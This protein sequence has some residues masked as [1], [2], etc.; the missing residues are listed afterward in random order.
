MASLRSFA[1]ELDPAA[2][3][4]ALGGHRTGSGWL[5]HCPAHDDQ[6]PSLSITGNGDGKLLVHCHAG[7]SQDEVITALRKLGLWPEQKAKPQIVAV[8]PYHDE[9]GELLYQVIRLEPKSFR[10]RQP[11]GKGG[12][13]WN[14]NGTRLVPYRLP[15][16][17]G[18]Q[19][20]FIVEGEKDADTIR[21]WGL[22]GSTNP[23][24]AL[25]WQP[26]FNQYFRDKLVAILP[27]KDNAGHKHALQ[28]ARS[29]LG[30]AR[31]VRI[32]ELPKAKDVSDWAEAGGT[33]EQLQK[34]V[35]QAP[36]LTPESLA[37]LEQRWGV[38]QPASQPVAQV[39]ATTES[40][41]AIQVNDRPLRDVTCDALKA[42]QG[43]NNPPVLFVRAGQL[44]VVQTDEHGR[45]SILPVTEAHLRGR[46]DR[47]ADFHRVLASGESKPVAPPLDVVRDLLALGPEQW[48]FPPLTGVSS[49]PLVRPDGTI[50]TTEGYDAK[51]QVYY[52]DQG[53]QLPPIP[54]RPT[55]QDVGKALDWIDHALGDFPFRGEADRANA[56][57]M[58]LTPLI[59]YALPR[60]ACLP[61]FLVD[62]PQS[63]TGKTL[64]A[65]VLA[66]LATGDTAALRAAPRDEDEWRKCLLSVLRAGT[67]LVVFDD[68]ATTLSA[69][70]LAGVITAHRWSDR[71][72]GQTAELALP[73]NTL[74]VATGNNL[75]VGGDLPRRSVWVRLDA[76][77]PRPWQGRDFRHPLLERWV[78]RHRGELLS[79]LLTLVRAWF[80]AGRPKG[81]A[82]S[83]LSF[84]PWCQMT[85]GI[86]THA[87]IA[88]FLGNAE[89]L[90]QDPET[91]GWAAFL[92]ALW[93]RFGRQPFT[94]A[95]L[96]DRV[97]FDADLRGTLP[98]E[99]AGQR[100]QRRWGRALSSQCERRFILGGVIYWLKPVG[101]M[102]GRQRWRVHAV[103]ERSNA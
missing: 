13:L 63:G 25:K 40:L 75:A 70:A 101:V 94:T 50:V 98:D 16:I 88:G 49:C 32:V 47:V 34:L 97:E 69:P 28:I 51:L 65:Q 86:L 74:F 79:A 38:S 103:K 90:W 9:S 87:G 83:L 73:V 57:A 80:A 66:T 44:V 17:I 23:F 95:E 58:L 33:R 3:A 8:Y 37:E 11:D 60:P 81:Q 43:A 100:D 31:E 20:V 26:S 59:R 29:L 5:A 19:Q 10:V 53:L 92:R 22:V 2:I 91:T 27:D 36:P 68:V 30:V 85:A 61:L 18:A 39:Q 35:A 24:G 76:K 96:A 12:W 89:Q 52:A 4:Q 72:L 54:D 55:K 21:S 77:S 78:L 56:I 42:L 48:R 84:G 45:R 64:L 1:T 102:H 46:L 41:P 7:C 93:K 62:A 99:L 67:N 15:E 14:L 82:P 71:V 6:H